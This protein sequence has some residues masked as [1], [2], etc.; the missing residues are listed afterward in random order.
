MQQQANA[1]RGQE[2]GATRG[3][4]EAMQQPAGPCHTL[5]PPPPTVV[6]HISL[7]FGARTSLI[8]AGCCLQPPPVIV[9]GCRKGLGVKMVVLSMM[10]WW[11][12]VA[13]NNGCALEMNHR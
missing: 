3:R 5:P 9:T 8:V 10:P 4:Q 6:Y 2:G 11:W 13:C 1:K 7:R 12:D